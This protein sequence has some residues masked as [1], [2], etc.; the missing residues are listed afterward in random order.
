MRPLNLLMN[1]KNKLNNF[2]PL[3]VAI[4][5]VLGFFTIYIL[6]GLDGWGDRASNENAVGQVSRWCERV[7][8][9][10]LREPSNTLGNL[11]FIFVGLYMFY[12]LSQD[13]T[14][15][16]GITM[17]GSSSIAVIYAGASTF[18]GPGSMAMHG[19]NTEFGAWL[20]NLSMIMYIIILWIYNLKKLIGF[21]TRIY[22]TI[23][24]LLVTLYALDSW[25]LAGGF[26]VGISLFELSI[27]LWIATEIVVKFPNIYGRISSGISVLIIQQL[28]G[29]PVL[30]SFQ[31]FQNNWEMLLYFSPALIPNLKKPSE[32]KYSPWFFLGFLSFFGAL[33]IWETGVPDHPWCNPDSWLQAHMIWH[34]LCSAATFS[35]FKLY[36]TEKYLT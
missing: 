1:Q 34:L 3:K 32:I 5:S 21:S 10:L 14:S 16:K 6:F 27:G 33:L 7:S 26:G 29:S 9:G 28:F 31:D 2:F 20:D 30:D 11:G 22:L 24:F 35:F 18:L 17:F 19:T 36:R 23:Y 15:E 13:A 8:D 12:K 25:F 4:Y